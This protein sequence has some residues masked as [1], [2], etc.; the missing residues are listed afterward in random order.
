[1]ND[2][3][4]MLLTA[5]MAKLFSDRQIVPAV[6]VIPYLIRR[7]NRSFS[8]AGRL[9]AALD[10]ASL[11]RPKGVSRKLAGQILDEISGET[12]PK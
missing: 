10:D 11:T 12:G 8:M 2:P 7:M 1:L 9:V 4:D 6:D 5:I 3:D